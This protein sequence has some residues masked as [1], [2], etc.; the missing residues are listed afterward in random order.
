MHADNIGDNALKRF[1]EMEDDFLFLEQKSVCTGIPHIVQASKISNK[2]KDAFP[3]YDFSYHTFH[4]KQTA[5]PG[6]TINR[7]IKCDA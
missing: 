6:K 7:K 1:V 5:E 3:S 2:I 4:L